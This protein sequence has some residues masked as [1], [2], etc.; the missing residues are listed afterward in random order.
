MTIF[1]R[2]NG[3]IR[4]TALAAAALAALCGGALSGC[5]P[6]DPLGPDPVLAVVDGSIRPGL[7][8]DRPSAAY[9]TITGGPAPVALVAVTADAAQRAEMH[10]TVRENGV[11]SMRAIQR[12]PVAA[13]ETV[14]F[15]PGG[16]HVM[17]FGL[18]PTA[19]RAG[20]TPMVFIFSNNDRIIADMII[21]PDQDGAATGG[22]TS[23][24]HSGHGG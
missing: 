16:R 24:E 7:T 13:N 17:L 2:M 11:V 14:R 9:F 15:A 19:V 6:G 18:N 22:S 1:R 8:A 20:R 23:G 12:V 3:H 10:E 5:K 4:P 21:T